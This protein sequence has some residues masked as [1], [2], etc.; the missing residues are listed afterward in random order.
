MSCD[1]QTNTIE[2][3]YHGFFYETWYR[4]KLRSNKE[5]EFKIEGHQGDGSGFGTYEISNDTLTFHLAEGSQPFSMDIEGEKYLIENDSCLINIWT[6]L[7]LCKNVPPDQE[8]SSSKRSIYY[9]YKK[10]VNNDVRD[11]MNQ[12]LFSALNVEDVRSYMPDTVDQV[13]LKSYHEISGQEGFTLSQFGKPVMVKTELE[14][15]QEGHGSFLEIMDINIQDDQML[16]LL[17]YGQTY[18]NY[19]VNFTKVEDGWEVESTK[20]Y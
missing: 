7:D 13:I 5:F 1:K 20:V 3:E 18:L 9:P 11:E 16:M 10:P 15:K 14:I 19:A 2:G 17:A 12:A 8:W 4:V 6:R